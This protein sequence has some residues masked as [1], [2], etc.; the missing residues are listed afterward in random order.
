MPLQFAQRPLLPQ[1]PPRR[2]PRPPVNVVALR[3]NASRAAP[4]LVPEET[5]AAAAA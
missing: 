1:L 2:R 5:R 3:P 4:R